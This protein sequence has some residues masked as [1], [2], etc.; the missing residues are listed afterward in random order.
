MRRI[1]KR[2]LS[3]VITTVLLIVL[4]I[5]LAIIILLWARTWLKEAVTKDD[6]PIADVCMDVSFEAS[7]VDHG[8]ALDEIIVS[9]T[10]N[11]N[12]YSFSV[13]A[14]KPGRITPVEERAQNIATGVEIDLGRGG[15]GNFSADFTGVEKIIVKPVLEGLRGEVKE[16]YVCDNHPGAE[17]EI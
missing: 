6:R 5:A 8:A 7:P 13:E 12:I 3:P 17:L 14:T 4:A 2:G 11:V 15:S 9:N 10:G 16:R 1:N